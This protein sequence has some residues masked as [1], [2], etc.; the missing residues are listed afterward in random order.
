MHKLYF[1]IA[2]SVLL[3]IAAAQ[4]S[5]AAFLYSKPEFCGRVIDSET[6]EPIAGAVV[7]VLYYKRSTFSLNPGGP[8]SFVTEAKETLT[9]KNGEFFFPS[10]SE[11]MY[12]N[13][14]VGARFIFFKPG[15]QA[16]Y[17]PTYISPLLTEKYFSAG[18]IAKEIE[19]EAGSFNNSSYVKWKGPLGIVELKKARTREEKLRTMPSPPANYTSKE[20]PILIK[21]INSEINNLGLKGEYK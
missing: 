19:I 12:L 14:D 17:G 11:L 8:S 15:Y 21:F 16:G 4:T 7:V 10:Y 20:L 2:F 3:V 9:D 6:K 5:Q 1:F 13:E 18:E